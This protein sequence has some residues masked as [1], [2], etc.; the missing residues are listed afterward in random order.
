[1]QTEEAHAAL[2]RSGIGT[3]GFNHETHEIHE[4]RGRKNRRGLAKAEKAAK[5]NRNNLSLVFAFAAKLLGRFS[6]QPQILLFV[7]SRVFGG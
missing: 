4:R 7:L 3:E 6:T 1:M 2:T 5:A